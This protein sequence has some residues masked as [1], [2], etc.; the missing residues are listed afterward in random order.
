MLLRLEYSGCS[1]ALSWHATTLNSWPQVSSCL[2]LLSSWDYRLSLTLLSMLEYS[3]MISADCTLCLPGSS[4]SPASASRV[5]GH[6]GACQHLLL[7][8]V[9][10]A[11]TG[12]HH[13]GQAGLKL[14]TS[15][16]PPALA[17]QSARIT[18][19]SKVQF[20]LECSGTVSA[21][22]NLLLLCLGNS[23]ASTSGGAEITSEWEFH[24]I[25]Q[26]GLE[27]LTSDGVSLLLSR[28]ECGGAISADC[29]LRLQSSSDSPPSVSQVGGIT[30]MHH[31]AQLI[32]IFSV[33]T[34]FL[35]VGQAGLKLPTAGDPSALASQSAGITGRLTL[36]PKLEC[37]G[38]ISA[39][40]NL[41][42]PSRFKQSL[43][44][45]PRLE[46]SDEISAHC[47]L[48][49]RGSS[50]SPASA[51]LVAGIQALE[52]GFH[53]VGQSG[54]KLLTS[55]DPPASASQ[56]AGITGVSHLAQPPM[57]F[58]LFVFLYLSCRRT[59]SYELFLKKLY[60]V[61]LEC[62]GTILGHCSLELLASNV[63]PY[64]RLPKRESCSVTRLECSGTIMA[65]CNLCLLGSSDSP[66]S[67][68]R[69]A[70]TT[71]VSHHARP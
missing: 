17:S 9:F 66:A 50:D 55:C 43:A 46:C 1:Q 67:A 40:C 64:F 63:P 24:H 60:N 20:R 16:D 48:C 38:M 62:S 71:G 65:H 52:T 19:L 23:P 34:R 25:D 56:S 31:H 6:T 21:H 3:G 68:S 29:N 2:S 4:D 11:E 36:L 33:E 13:V 49:L 22:C 39:Y 28:L 18:H 61:V 15:S 44:L 7:I 32:F 10:L 58:C 57:S 35:H 59:Q 8:S 27:L 54:L 47:N 14:L 12:F 53:R 69:V 41:P 5:T 51:S 70:G 45:L 42:L 30:C 26:A 37:N